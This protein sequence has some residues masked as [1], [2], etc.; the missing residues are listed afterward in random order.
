MDKLTND[1]L[2]HY[3]TPRKSGRYPWGSG[4]NPYQSGGD[5]LAA[6]EKYADEG[7]NRTQIS[8]KL[9]ITTGEYDIQRARAIDEREQYRMDSIKSMKKRGMSNVEIGK[10]LGISEGSVRNLIKKAEAPVRQSIN[11]VADALEE[12]LKKGEHLDVGAGAHLQLGISEGRLKAAIKELEDRGYSYH[13]LQIRR[14]QDY[15]NYVTTMVL[16]SE[17]NHLKVLKD[18]ENIKQANIKMDRDTLEFKELG[19][20][21]NVDRTRIEV[22][23]GDE[24]GSD[25]DGLIE[26]RPGVKD[27]DLN[28]SSY[29]QVRIGVEG[30]LFMKGMVV[31]VDDLPKGIDIRYNVNKVKGTPDSDVFKKQTGDPTNPFGSSITDQRGALN[32][33][34]EEGSWS[35]W[36]K[37]LSSQFLS[38]QPI[39]LVRERLT[40]TFDGLQDQYDE[41]ISLNNS[42]V[43]KHLLES[44]IDDL[45]AKSRHLKVQGLPRTRNHVLIPY[46]DIRPNEVYAPGYKNGERVVLVR[47]PHGGTFELPELIVN[48]SHASAKKQIGNALDAIGIHPTVA[49]KMSGADFDGDTVLV[50]PNDA[51][52]IKASRSLTGLKNFDPNIYKVDPKIRKTMSEGTKDMEMGKVSNL[53]TDMSI[54]DASQSELAR[55]VRHSMVVIDAEK[56][57]LDYKKSAEDNGIAALKRR[58]QLHIKPTTGRE[59]TGAS[60]LI[61]TSK[62][63]ETVKVKDPRTGKTRN[64]KVYLVDMFD[65]ARKLSSGTAVENTYADYINKNKAL[66]NE[67]TKTYLNTK[68]TT[69]DRKAN[70]RYSKEVANLDRQLRRALLNAP[71]ERE[72]QRKAANY[73]YDHWDKDE[74]SKDDVKKLK[75]RAVAMSRAESGANK[76]LIKI[77]DKEWEAIQAGAI[78]NTKLKKILENTDMDRVKELATPRDLP[79]MSSAKASRAKAMLNNGYTYAE[80]SDAVGMSVTA[81]REELDL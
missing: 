65:D 17:E 55:A 19:P 6:I 4:E 40:S 9:G 73:F 54:K 35:D 70:T 38:K 25:K 28:T 52:K 58:Y 78:S 12:R 29:A 61:S 44:F 51:G 24:G 49:E 10:Q 46:P 71:R 23:Y 32:I 64:E 39:R 5:F 41:I 57:N 27:L 66:R 48:N 34:N 31:E 21:Q 42:A 16:S 1:I 63:E 36:S 76:S 3:G 11:T 77:S 26:I 74:M 79:K 7:L 81:I 2:K 33:I 37:T 50:I 43:R 30:D 8:K 62:R 60:T 15:K 20:I 45:G 14:L 67:A 13:K 72:A 18:S 59:S 47:H 80:V 68:N 56:H 69:Y 53:I 22:K 75:T